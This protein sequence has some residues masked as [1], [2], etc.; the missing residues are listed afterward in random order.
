MTKFYKKPNPLKKADQI[1]IAVAKTLNK[2]DKT[3]TPSEIAGYLG[4]HPNTAKN[5]IEKLE[6]EGYVKCKKDGNR[7]YCKRIK[8]IKVNEM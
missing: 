4:I 7:W 2:I 1:G 6:K 3:V 5:R 8:K